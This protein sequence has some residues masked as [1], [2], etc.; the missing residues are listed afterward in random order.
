MSLLVTGS[1]ALD[2]VETPHGSANDVLGGSA[3]YF[4]L[5]AALFAPVR[6]VGVV[7]EDFEPRLL[8]PLASRPI[9]VSGVEIRRGSRT[10]RWRGRYQGAMNDAETVGVQLNVLAE[11][12]A[13]VP[14]AFMD[15]RCVFLA[16]THPAL[17]LGFAQTLSKAELI[18]CDTMNLWIENER[19]ALLRTLRTVHGLVL[20]EGE[21]RLLTGKSN[22]VSA[23]R[24]IL[25]LG[26][27]F[28]VIKKGEHGSLLVSH[29]DLF[30]APAYP[31]ERTID[32][33][34]CGD[35][36]AG[37]MMGYLAAHR[38]YDRMALRRAMLH[39]SVTASFVIESFSIEALT[40]VTPEDV[41]ERLREL[42]NMIR[43][44]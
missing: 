6:I 13:T 41:A 15:S 42:R 2:S 40:R 38:S 20:N 23:G 32:P 18:V 25:K 5:A 17:Q 11:R 34:G 35:T 21:A 30:V 12:G 8:D 27:R 19:E 43:C 7:G 28:A 37:A 39:G 9:D 31:T 44:D 10:F 3:V 26:P 24:E 22:L 29:D 33:T 36:F 14:P 1:I 4:S 16:N